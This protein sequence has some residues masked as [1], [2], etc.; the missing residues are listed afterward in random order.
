M[1]NE[2]QKGKEGKH[3]PQLAVRTQVQAGQQ[4]FLSQA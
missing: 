1:Q 4:G 3:Y 2:L